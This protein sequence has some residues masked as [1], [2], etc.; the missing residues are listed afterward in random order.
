MFFRQ[1]NFYKA[2]LAAVLI[3]ASA[4][5][6]LRAEDKKPT[7]ALS[8]A[9]YG[10]NWRH[11]MV[12]AFEKAAEEAKSKGLLANY[13]ELN[14]DNTVNAQIGQMSDLI[15]KKVDAIIINAASLTGVN[16]VVEKACAAGIVVVAFDSI[17][18][19]PCAYNITWDFAGWQGPLTDGVMKL[20]GGKGNIIIVRGVRGSA[21]DESIYKEEIETLKK[22][23]DV[24]V[25]STV[26]GMASSSVAQTAVSNVLP[27]L[28]PIAA[29]IG[30]AGMFGVAQ[31]FEQ[32]GGQYADHMPVI[33]GDGD[34]SFIHWWIEQQKKN[35]YTTLS[36]NTAPS[37]S[38][39][40]LWVALAILR[41]EKVPK[42][43]KMSVFTVTNDNVAK[44]ADLKPGTVVAPDFS[45]EW[46]ET[47]LLKQS[48]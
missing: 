27:S 14:G 4:S 10:N 6:P 2:M 31:A 35:G 26:Y 3:G 33:G 30:D 21:P 46:V 43:M 12:Q 5:G 40:A 8:N 25:V 13:I 42:E 32:F 36:M 23:P 7:V 18:S 37:I 28:P 44:F 24:K 47:N 41:G 15:L 9:Y 48:Q 20:I 38:Q 29:V 19:A 17:V 11:Q 45:Q 34:A 39:A 22:Y 1:A 16:G